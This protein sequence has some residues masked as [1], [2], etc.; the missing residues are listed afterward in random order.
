MDFR[1][2]RGKEIARR[3]GL[4]RQ[5]EV[6]LVPSQSRVGKRYRVVVTDQK[7]TCT[8]ADFLAN[9]RTCKHIHAVIHRV[10]YPDAGLVDPAPVKKAKTKRKTYPQDWVNYNA[11]QTMEKPHFM[12]LLAGLCEFVE[13]DVDIN[14]GP[15]RPRVRTSDLVFLI[16]HKV[17]EQKSTRRFMPYADDDY[18]K[19]FV[20]CLPHFNSINNAMSDE[21]MTDAL[22]KII[23]ISSLPFRGLEQNFAA[24]SSGFTVSQYDRWQEVK[25]GGNT[26]VDSNPAK[27]K[28]K[29][30]KKDKGTNEDE[31][32]EM[33]R[34]VWTK[35]HLICGVNTHI[36]TA[37]VIKDKDA[38]DTRQ[39]PDLIRQTAQNFTI[40][41]M[42][43]DKAYGSIENYQMMAELGVDPFIP[44]KSNQTG[45]GKGRSGQEHK[46]LGGKLWKKKGFMIK[47]APIL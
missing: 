29:Q 6:W 32:T 43:A 37:V 30:T 26:D 44:F 40:K 15:G 27:K 47:R 46:K 23:E 21:R 14:P 3:G 31:V 1:E 42:L 20:S 36:V 10:P 9:G 17:Y 12:E 4:V 35:V 34:Q 24:D 45:S 13:D 2:E 5:G 25:R 22:L 18:R 33:E 7:K 8:C 11:A 16:N 39:L 28:G 41:H 38:S 19:G